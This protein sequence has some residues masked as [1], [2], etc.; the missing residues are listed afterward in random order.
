MNLRRIFLKFLLVLKAID[1]K[2]KYNGV[3]HWPPKSW[4]CRRRLLT[5]IM[6]SL[7]L[8]SYFKGGKIATECIG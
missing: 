6:A 2:R 8:S 3:H 4:S 7:G 1:W 5:V